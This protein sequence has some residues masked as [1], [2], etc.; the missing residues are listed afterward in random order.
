MF[1]ERD[2]ADDGEDDEDGEGNEQEWLFR[3]PRYDN[4]CNCCM[5]QNVW[6]NF[7]V[8]KSMKQTQRFR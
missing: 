2:Y 5:L 6:R 7:I 8:R 1:D 4:C 3:K